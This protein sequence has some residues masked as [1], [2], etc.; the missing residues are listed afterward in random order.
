MG[1]LIEEKLVQ[2]SFL[3]YLADK[4][5]LIWYI[6]GLPQS[7][8]F[9]RLFWMVLAAIFFIALFIFVT[10][11]LTWLERKLLAFLQQRVG[12]SK[13]GRLGLL[14]SLADAFKLMQKEDIIPFR[15]DKITFIIAPWVIIIPMIIMFS[16]IPLGKMMID[17]RTYYLIGKDV[18]IGVLLVLTAS[19]FNLIG[20]VIAGWS[21]NN[22]YAVLGALRSA[23][24]LLSYELPMV[25]S[26]LAVA[27]VASSLQFTQMVESQYRVWNIL[28]QFFGALVFFIA[29]MSETNRHPFDLPES[30][31]ELSAGF[32][33]E[34]GGLRFAI[35]YITEYAN[36]F[37]ISIVISICYMGGWWSPFR[38]LVAYNNWTM[39]HLALPPEYQWISGLFWTLGK[40]FLIILLFIWARAALP[41]F[42]VDQVTIFAWRYMF[43]LSLLNFMIAGMGMNFNHPW[44]MGKVQK[45]NPLVTGDFRLDVPLSPLE[46]FFNSKLAAYHTIGDKIFN[47]FILLGTLSIFVILVVIT[48]RAMLLSYRSRYQKQLA[49]RVQEV[50]V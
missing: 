29:G 27:I 2:N 34:Y 20:I 1:A 33:S 31:G 44:Y 48:L 8:H 46:M 21:S 18:H 41:R 24:Q 40:T 4:F 50:E 30:Y 36:L 6:P 13:V 39:E 45:Y 25:T 47:I 49:N 35:F 7:Y 10:L 16:C 14:Q 15:A 5:G 22:R 43:P 3:D 42:R 11:V 38:H 26:L 17:D 12:P 23:A 37:M 19:A 28:P 9:N 32:M